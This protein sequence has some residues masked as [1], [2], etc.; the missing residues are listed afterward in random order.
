MKQSK[1]PKGWDENRVRRILDHYENQT[2]AE[3]VA[4]DDAPGENGSPCIHSDSRR[5][6]DIC[7][8]ADSPKRTDIRSLRGKYSGVLS[9][10]EEFAKR[11]AKEKKLKL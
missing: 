9:S 7:T 6:S 10:T 11:K 3:A 8:K 4:E 1:F 5:A 2:E